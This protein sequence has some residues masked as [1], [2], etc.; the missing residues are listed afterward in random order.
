MRDDELS[1]RQGG[2]IRQLRKAM[3]W[4]QMALAEKIGVTYQQV[5]KYEKG[6]S[7][8]NFVRAKQIAEAFEVSPTIFFDGEGALAGSAFTEEE[9]KVICRFRRLGKRER[10]FVSIKNTRS[11]CGSPRTSR[12]PRICRPS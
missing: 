3:G 12:R 11:R 2:L 7:V 10:G 1:I 8:L 4:S 5:Q 9:L 6:S